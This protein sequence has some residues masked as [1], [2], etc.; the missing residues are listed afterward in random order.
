MTNFVGNSETVCSLIE[1]EVDG[2]IVTEKQCE[3]YC[4]T[5][6]T[7]VPAFCGKDKTQNER[8]ECVRISKAIQPV[9]SPD[10]FGDYDFDYDY[11]NFES[12]IP[13]TAPE[14]KIDQPPPPPQI[15]QPQ[16]T[17]SWLEGLRSSLNQF[18]GLGDF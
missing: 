13:A 3:D 4:K 15:N 6:F 2:E 7:N 10:Y 17:Q 16:E 18:L 11:S 9:S 14:I 12:S 5:S 8:G 1:K